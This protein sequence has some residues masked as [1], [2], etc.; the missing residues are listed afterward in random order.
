V[1]VVTVVDVFGMLCSKLQ[2]GL[3]TVSCALYIAILRASYLLHNERLEEK[4][5]GKSL[6]KLPAHMLVTHF[7]LRFRLVYYAV[8]HMFERDQANIVNIESLL[9]NLKRKG[10]TKI[11]INDFLKKK[12]CKVDLTVEAITLF[13]HVF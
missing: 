3:C 8:Y 1:V 4:G 6:V 2:I 11:K 12:L 5:D 9:F 13:V 10:A 7:M